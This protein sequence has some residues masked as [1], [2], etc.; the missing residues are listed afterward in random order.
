MRVTVRVTV[1]VALRVALRVTVRLALR[2]ALRVAECV[3]V[4]VADLP[5]VW[6]GDEG[7]EGGEGRPLGVGEPVLRHAGLLTD[8]AAMLLLTDHNGML[9]PTDHA[10]MLRRRL[11]LALVRARGACARM[12]RTKPASHQAI[13]QAPLL[14]A[15]LHWA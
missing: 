15:S 9:L 11:A 10:A 13:R 4:L 7:A 12:G 8:H 2:V 6:A 14:M 5:D 1:L 3:T